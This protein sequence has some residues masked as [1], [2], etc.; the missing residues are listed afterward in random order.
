MAKTNEIIVTKILIT[1]SKQKTAMPFTR[2]FKEQ[3][4][5]CKKKFDIVW[6]GSS[7]HQFLFFAQQG[8]H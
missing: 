4:F 1:Y 8:M 3:S 7:C 2:L 5:F 6:F